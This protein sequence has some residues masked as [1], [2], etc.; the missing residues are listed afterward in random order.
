MK[1]RQSKITKPAAK[2]SARLTPLTGILVPTPTQATTGG[3]QPLPA[4]TPLPGEF[5][6][7]TYKKGFPLSAVGGAVKPPTLSIR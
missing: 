2:Q 6:I 4:M 7:A 5:L 1:K 3:S